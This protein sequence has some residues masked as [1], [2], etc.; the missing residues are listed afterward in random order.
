MGIV[1]GE[2]ANAGHATEF[3]GLF[4]A[5]NRAEFREAHGQVAV[6]VMIAREDLDV[7]RAVHRLEQVAFEVALLESVDE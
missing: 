1:L 2:A 3:A 5:V 7:V 6:G 4:P